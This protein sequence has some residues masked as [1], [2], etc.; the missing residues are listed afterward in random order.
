[1]R[2]LILL[3]LFVSSVCAQSIPVLSQSEIQQLETTVAQTPTDP[4]SQALLGQ[5]Y[6]FVILG[7]TSLG[8]IQH[9]SEAQVAYL[10]ARAS[11]AQAL[12]RAVMLDPGTATWRSYRIPILVF[13]SNFDFCP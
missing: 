5:N 2:G 1:V 13:R 12:D 8:Q 9:Q 6:S 3:P 7:I 4:Q 11:G 10:D